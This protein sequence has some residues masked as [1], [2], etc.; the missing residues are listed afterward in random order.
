MPRYARLIYNGYWWA[1]ER[2]ALQ[3]LIDYSQETVNGTVTIRL[4]K[5][6]IIIRSRYSPNTLYNKK[7]STFE[8]DDGAY[9]QKDAEGFIK[10]NSLRLRMQNKK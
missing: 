3:K 4:H 7:L 6:N 8:E 9:D 10:V 2:Y 1:P 5:G